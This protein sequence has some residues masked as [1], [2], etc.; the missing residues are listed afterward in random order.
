MEGKHADIGLTEKQGSSYAKWWY[1]SFSEKGGDLSIKQ[2]DRAAKFTKKE[3]ENARNKALLRRGSEPGTSGAPS[4]R[5]GNLQLRG[6]R[7][8][9]EGLDSL[10]GGRGSRSGEVS[11]GA[12]SQSGSTEGGEVTSVSKDDLPKNP[13]LKRV[14]G[15]SA[16]DFYSQ[17]E[18]TI[19]QKMPNSAS[20][21][22]VRGM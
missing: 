10:P 8:Q 22:Q 2:F 19:E 12:K 13:P 21:E 4:Q 5:T 14:E 17:L 20:A 11:G 16:P 18:R 7:T 9:H 3:L 6:T 1:N 15:E